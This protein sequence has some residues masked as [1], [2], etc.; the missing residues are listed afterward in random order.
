M[1]LYYTYRAKPRRV[2]TPTE[3]NC[4][5]LYDTIRD[6]RE[7]K[8]NRQLALI[9]MKLPSK[10]VSINNKL[11]VN[12]FSK[13]FLQ[14]YPDYYEVIKNPIDMEKIA[15]K[16]KSNMYET[17][18]DLVADF[19]LMF[20]NA[21]K[22]N[23]PDSQI[24]KDALVLQ[25]VCLQTKLQLKEDDD[26][27]PDVPAAVQDLLLNLFTNVYNYQDTDERCYSDS[28][29]DLPEHDEVDGKK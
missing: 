24:Y 9:F 4:R 7:P 11:F 12:F 8:A 2:L 14:D 23:E 17:L 15:H 22:Y 25:R 16:L 5:T 1:S 26:T 20:D 3:K 29:A 18:D 13:S 21:C 10:N 19:V 6:Y 27:I 28:M